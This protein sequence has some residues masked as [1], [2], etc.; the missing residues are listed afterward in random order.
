MPKPLAALVAG[1]CLGA[2]AV[3]G[4]SKFNDDRGIGDAPAD[5]QPDRPVKVW[6]GPDRFMNVGA[7]CIGVNGIYIHT[8]EAAPVVIPNDPN[9]DEGGILARK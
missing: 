9:C 4:C 3:A 5:Q 2:I 6:A 1:L 7:Y 8:R